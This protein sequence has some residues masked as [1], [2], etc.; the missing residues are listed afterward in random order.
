M[1]AATA[2]NCACVATAMAVRHAG[3]QCRRDAKL[4]KTNRHR[5]RRLTRMPPL[6]AAGAPEGKA[7]TD[8]IFPPPRREVFAFFPPPLRGEGD[9]GVVDTLPPP[10]D[11]PGP[12]DP[13]L[14]EE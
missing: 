11:T 9:R 8:I 1:A 3:A 4:S 2:H 10:W 5:C 14:Y 13:P 7:M 6:V 12:E